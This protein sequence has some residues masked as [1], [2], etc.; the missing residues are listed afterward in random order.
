MSVPRTLNGICWCLREKES[1]GKWEWKQVTRYFTSLMH[2]KPTLCFTM[3]PDIVTSLLSPASAKQELL[4]RTHCILNP[5]VRWCAQACDFSWLENQIY[6]KLIQRCNRWHGCTGQRGKEVQDLR[7]RRPL[8]AF[9]TSDSG[10]AQ[11]FFLHPAKIVHQS[12]TMGW[13]MQSVVE[14]DVN[15]PIPFLSCIVLGLWGSSHCV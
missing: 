6:S 5:L 12:V 2:T 15:F 11:T 1:S 13:I 9:S 8:D 14:S 3:G 4:Q 10:L 7:H